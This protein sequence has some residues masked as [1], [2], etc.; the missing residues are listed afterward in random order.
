VSA[1]ATILRPERYPQRLAKSGGNFLS[2]PVLSEHAVEVKDGPF[3]VTNMRGSL[4]VT[5]RS[6]TMGVVRYGFSEVPLADESALLGKWWQQYHTASVANNWG[7][8]CSTVVEGLNR[9]RSLRFEPKY[10]V[11]PKAEF[12]TGEKEE[13][14]VE[15]LTLAQGFV[16]DMGDVKV[17]LADL[18]KGAALV[19]TEP[20][21]VGLYTRV[22]DSLGV[23]FRCADQ[24]VMVVGDGLV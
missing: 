14:Q 24:S 6:L 10:V 15:R 19:T 4:V 12:L 20:M 13:E 9:M 17:L 23:V 21:L 3:L 16:A 7:N 5:R 2:V 18:P 8:R 1:L 22:G 11:L